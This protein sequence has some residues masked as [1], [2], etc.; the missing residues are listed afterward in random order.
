MWKKSGNSTHSVGYTYDNINNPTAWSRNE[1]IGDMMVEWDA[2]NE[3]FHL[4]GHERCLHVDID[5]K[6]KG[7][8]RVDYWKRA[9]TDT[10]KG[11]FAC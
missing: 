6:D 2:H 7:L 9:I 3:L 1:D 11:F 4:S 10:L 8:T 5:N